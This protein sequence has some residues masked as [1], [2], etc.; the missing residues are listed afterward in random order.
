MPIQSVAAGRS[1]SVDGRGHAEV[2]ALS[3][4]SSFL[5]EKVPGRL[6]LD[7]FG[8]GLQVEGLGQADDGP[9]QVLVGGVGD[10]IAYELD[11]V[12]EVSDRKALKVREAAE[13]GAKVVEG[14]AASQIGQALGERGS[15]VDVAH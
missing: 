9:D 2:E 3:I 4:V 7:A 1:S 13:A 14:E 12:L 11:V 10:Q 5:A 15:G 8:D 6:V